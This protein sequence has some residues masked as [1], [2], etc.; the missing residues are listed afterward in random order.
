T[1]G[2]CEDLSCDRFAKRD[3]HGGRRA[4]AKYSGS[5]SVCELR[6]NHRR[7][8]WPFLSLHAGTQPLALQSVTVSTLGIR[9]SIRRREALSHHLESSLH[10]GAVEFVRFNRALLVSTQGGTEPLAI[11]SGS[12]HRRNMTIVS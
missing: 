10:S 3:F 9:R 7:L 8:C 6:P 4:R 2:L 1:V 12:K 5:R 11:A